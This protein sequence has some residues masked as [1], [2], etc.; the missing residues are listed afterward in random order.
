M[1]HWKAPTLH[2][3]APKASIWFAGACLLSF[4]TTQPAHAE[5]ATEW[6]GGSVVDLGGLPGRAYSIADGI[7]NAGEV[8]GIS[9]VDGF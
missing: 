9:Y 5:T 6:S 1:S 7:N 2:S 4:G 8:V 3:K